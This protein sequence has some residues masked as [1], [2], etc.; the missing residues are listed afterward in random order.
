LTTLPV[1]CIYRFTNSGSNSM[2]TNSSHRAITLMELLVIIVIVGVIAVLLAPAWSRSREAKNR[3]ICAGNLRQI[4]IAM[5]T[6][7]ADHQDHLPTVIHNAGGSIWD[8]ALV[9]PGYLNISALHCPSDKNERPDKKWPR[10]Y[11]LSLGRDGDTEDF[12]IQGSELKC[13]ALSN[14]SE[15][16]IIGE[17]VL[18]PAGWQNPLG[19]RSTP[20]SYGSQL[21][22]FCSKKWLVSAHFPAPDPTPTTY[23][24]VAN[25]LYVDGHVA[26]VEPVTD[27]LLDQM[28]PVNPDGRTPCP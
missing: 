11:A 20:G 16:V 21:A 25:Y 4:G 24:K 6:Y 12:W 7:A 18:D 2:N 22:S 27:A 17:R 5:L 28:F 13:P 1:K 10:S 23:V 8:V 19:W 14:R 9:Q 15:I 3:A 26:W